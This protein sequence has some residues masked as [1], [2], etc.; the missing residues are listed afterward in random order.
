VLALGG[1]G[2]VV[3][4]RRPTLLRVFLVWGF[5]LSLI[6]YSWAGEKFPWLVLHPL[7]PLLLLAGL[8]VQT[9]W[10][11]R[12]SRYGAVALAA[13]AV[14]LCYTAGASFLVNTR[15]DTDPREFLVSTQSSA[16]VKS[17]A[18]Q[19]RAEAEA[20][21]RAGRPY[22]ITVDAAEGATYPYAWYFRD[23]DVNYQDLSATGS[24]P[25][26]ADA[27]I[28]TQGSRNRLT[29]QLTGSD[30]SERAFRFR[31][32]WVREYDRMS[33]GTWFRW[34]TQREPWNLPGGMPQ[35]LYQR[36]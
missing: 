33:P 2:T 1:V 26:D 18:D 10:D 9:I 7:L 35:W 11:A 14:A 36:R 13:T 20:A 12:R 32:W 17:V 34:F 19:L 21:E 16:D 6:V 27:L 3:A 22:N 4:L 30:Y 31:V 28:L 25:A 8:G 24:P 15:N 23:L 5:A 29:A